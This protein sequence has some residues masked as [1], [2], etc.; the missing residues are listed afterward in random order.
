ML[1]PLETFFAVYQNDKLVSYQ[2]GPEKSVEHEETFRESFL[3]YI[4]TVKNDMEHVVVVDLEDFSFTVVLGIYFITNFIA[5]TFEDIFV[6][7]LH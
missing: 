3:G 4:D 1:F 6:D 7:T 5:V 2:L